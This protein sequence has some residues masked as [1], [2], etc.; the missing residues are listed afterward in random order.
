MAASSSHDTVQNIKFLTPENFM[1]LYGTLGTNQKA[2]Q[3]KHL[4]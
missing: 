1:E 2:L 4:R 3:I